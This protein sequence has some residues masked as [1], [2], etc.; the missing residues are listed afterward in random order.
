MVYCLVGISHESQ[1]NIYKN[2]GVAD[3][4]SSPPI[5]ATA[6]YNESSDMVNILLKYKLFILK[7]RYYQKYS[8]IKSNQNTHS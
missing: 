6:T 8:Q 7:K 1:N 2:S 5:T 3:Q 4:H